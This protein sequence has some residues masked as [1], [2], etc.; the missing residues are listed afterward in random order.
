[1]EHIFDDEY[2]RNPLTGR[3][4]LVRGS[5]GKRVLKMY[6]ERAFED[7]K[8]TKEQRDRER[9]MRGRCDSGFVWSGLQKKCILRHTDE[10]ERI[11]QCRKDKMLMTLAEFENGQLTIGRSTKPV[12]KR[13]QA[14]AIGYSAGHRYC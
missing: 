1:M 11:S 12:V 9:R 8:M 14:L 10:G 4:V 5:A 7:M 6:G 2:V 3:V 13:D